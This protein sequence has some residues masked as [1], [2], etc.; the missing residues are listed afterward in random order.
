MCRRDSVYTDTDA[1]IALL[2]KLCKEHGIRGAESNHWRFGGEGALELA[3]AVVEACE[4]VSYTHLAVY[5]RQAT[6]FLNEVA[7]PRYN[8]RDDRL[9]SM[10]DESVDRFCTCILCQSFAP[11][12]CCGVTPERLGLC[13]AVSWLDA[14]AVS[15]T[16]LDVY[17]RQ[18]YEQIML[19]VS[20]F[21][22]GNMRL[23]TVLAA[24]E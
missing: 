20:D 15:Y 8:A 23:S 11:A 12:H 21:A 9:A 5:K 14:K 4:A 24:M 3:Q 2:K 19:A 10:T 7:M 13:G 1:E 18:A 16:H 6:K 17:K 22:K